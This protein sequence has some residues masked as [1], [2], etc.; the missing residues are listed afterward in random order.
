MYVCALSN[1]HCSPI[2]DHAGHN[3]DLIIWSCGC[4]V[5]LSISRYISIDSDARI[6]T[7]YRTWTSLILCTF[8]VPLHTCTGSQS[9]SMG[10]DFSHGH[11]SEEGVDQDLKT[12]LS[13]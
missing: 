10:R 4:N 8:N 12:A 7:A 3:Y 11:Y 13:R 1:T 9:C 6:E 5:V 2:S